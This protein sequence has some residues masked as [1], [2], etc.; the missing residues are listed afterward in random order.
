MRNDEFE[1]IDTLLSQIAH[2]CENLDVHAGDIGESVA[3]IA[4]LKTVAISMDGLAVALV[5]NVTDLQEE[6]Y[7][8]LLQEAKSEYFRQR[9]RDGGG[10]ESNRQTGPADSADRLEPDMRTIVER[11]NA[12]R[13]AELSAKRPRLPGPDSSLSGLVERAGRKTSHAAYKEIQSARLAADDFPAFVQYMREGKISI[14]YVDVLRSVQRTPELLALAKENERLLLDWAATQSVKEFRRSLRGW[15]RKNGARAA[16]RAEP[17]RRRE[18]LMFYPEDDGYKVS[19][20]LSGYSGSAVIRA[21]HDAGKLIASAPDQPGSFE[22]C[23]DDSGA[24][25]TADSVDNPSMCDSSGRQKDLWARNERYAQAL[26]LVVRQNAKMKKQLKMCSCSAKAWGTSRAQTL[27]APLR[28]PSSR[29]AD[30]GYDYREVTD[31]WEAPKHPTGIKVSNS[32]IQ[33]E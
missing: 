32:V 2:E 14:A 20:W 30:R 16:R 6:Q 28:V 13:Y 31:P 19:G 5:G 17:R 21:L 27:G 9:E 18:G 33:R 25:S 7:E 10:G 4:K 26:V 3:L 8:T 24:L 22:E 1:R 23:N 29:S 12:Q 11:E 15:E